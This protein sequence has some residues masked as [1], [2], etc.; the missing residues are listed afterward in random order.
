MKNIYS[1]CLI[2]FNNYFYGIKSN[3]DNKAVFNLFVLL[4][5]M[6]AIAVAF[7]LLS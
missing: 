3:E 4:Y 5:A 2:L 7:I 1:N 6:L